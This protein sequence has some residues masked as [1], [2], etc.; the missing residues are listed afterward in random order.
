MKVTSI[1]LKRTYGN[2]QNIGMSAD[3]ED[4]EDVSEAV[5]KLESVID[6]QIN[7]NRAV[8]QA[9][10]DINILNHQSNCLKGDVE[11]LEERKN[12]LVE[13]F[14]SKGPNIDNYNNLPF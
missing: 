9:T 13:W 1:S 3:V 6:Q 5:K 10:S 11:R 4:G 7:S 8:D 14:K 12:E 2:Y